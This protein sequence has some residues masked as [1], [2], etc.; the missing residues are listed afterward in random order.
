MDHVQRNAMTHARATRNPPG[1]SMPK[2][3]DIKRRVVSCRCPSTAASADGKRRTERGNCIRHQRNL[4]FVAS[5]VLFPAALPF[6]TFSMANFT[7]DFRRKLVYRYCEARYVIESICIHCGTVIVCTVYTG[8]PEHEQR[9]A[10][11]CPKKQPHK[12]QNVQ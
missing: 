4:P 7:P 8:V 9:H 3:T 2:V 12:T 10:A 1:N 6:K 11:Q 5:A